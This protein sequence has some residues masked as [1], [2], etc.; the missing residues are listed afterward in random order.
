VLIAFIYNL[1]EAEHH[2]DNQDFGITGAT[3][4]TLV[5]ETMAEISQSFEF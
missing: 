2:H 5:G 3:Q 4:G 1:I